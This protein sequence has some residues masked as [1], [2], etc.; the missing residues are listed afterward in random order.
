MSMGLTLYADLSLEWY[1]PWQIGVYIDIEGSSSNFGEG[2][3]LG[4]SEVLEHPGSDPDYACPETYWVEDV[5]VI[6]LDPAHLLL[7]DG[8]GI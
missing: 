5:A 3:L 1:G 2:D 4:L 6:V 7:G 8:Q